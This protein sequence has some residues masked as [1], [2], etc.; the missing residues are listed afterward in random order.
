MLL[1]ARILAIFL[2]ALAVT[3]TYHDFKRGKESLAMFSFWSVIWL[4]VFALA[5]D[6]NLVNLLIQK[7]Q[8][9]GI[10]IGTFLAIILVF[11]L[12]LIYRIYEKAHRLE[13]QLRELVTK[14]GLKDIDLQ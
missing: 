11:F 4:G 2:S 12:Y 7:T 1:I 6:P 14:I 8:G 5:V 10:G 9:Q 3:K 13:I